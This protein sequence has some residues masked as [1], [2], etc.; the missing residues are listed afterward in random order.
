MQN[1][2]VRRA[3]IAASLLLRMLHPPRSGQLCIR[4]L[5]PARGFC[6]FWC[7][8]SPLLVLPLKLRKVD[9]CISLAFRSSL[10]WMHPGWNTAITA[11]GAGKS[12]KLL[13]LSREH[14]LGRVLP[15]DTVGTGPL[16]VWM[17]QWFGEDF[18]ISFIGVLEASSPASVV[19][20]PWS[21]S[22]KVGPGHRGWTRVLQ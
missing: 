18:P 8:D 16:V 6:S 3:W 2:S 11:K 17:S 12:R 7:A 13:K 21:L 9:C 1:G 4:I 15:R 10:S 22:W 5:S 14:A 19:D 20:T